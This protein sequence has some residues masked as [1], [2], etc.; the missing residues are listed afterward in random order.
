MNASYL[1][2]N[3][4]LADLILQLQPEYGITE[5][6]LPGVTLMRVNQNT[7]RIPVFYE[8][9]IFVI[10]QGRKVG[11]LGEHTW[12]YDAHNYLVMSVPLPFEC[13]TQIH[14]TEPFLGVRI[15]VDSGLLRELLLQMETLPDINHA[16][17]SPDVPMASVPQ[18]CTLNDAVLRLMQCLQNPLESHVLGPQL[19]REIVFRALQGSQGTALRAVV[20]RQGN[21]SRMARALRRMHTEYA[22]ALDID[23]LAQEANMSVS[24]F[25]HNFK[26]MTFTS[27]LQYLKRV[28]LH[29]ALLLMVQDGLNVSAAANRV[30][31]ESPSQ[32]S[33]EFKRCFGRSPVEEVGAALAQ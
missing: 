11:Y 1:P 14:G 31:Y 16:E 6:S 33:R 8:P 26:A 12:Q 19:V 5:T 15:P 28:R 17:T 4:P 20:G 9:G 13:E 25:H 24:A 7:P 27:P 2:V 22:S 18:D 3:Q 23:T 21:F 30:G 10:A 32:F 29:K